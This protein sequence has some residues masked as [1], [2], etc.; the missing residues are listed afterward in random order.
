MNLQKNSSIVNVAPEIDVVNKNFAYLFSN[1][2]D[3]SN[4]ANT[5]SGESFQF[6]FEFFDVKFFGGRR[7]EFQGRS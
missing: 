6:T 5:E 1:L 3:N 4:I 2:K 7:F